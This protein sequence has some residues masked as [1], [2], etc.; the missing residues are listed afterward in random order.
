MRPIGQITQEH[1]DNEIQTA[2]NLC[3]PG[4]HE[5]I[6]TVFRSGNIPRSSCCFIDMEYCD[7]NLNNYIQRQWNSKMR[8]QFPNFIEP[9]PAD[10]AVQIWGIM[11]DI[12]NGVAFIHSHKLVHRDLKPQN[13]F[14]NAYHADLSSLF[15]QGVRHPWGLESGRFWTYRGSD[16]Q[17][18]T[19]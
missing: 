3:K 19:Y 12:A 1:I 7:L 6:V 5:N 8:S 10:E 11:I 15:P 2:L 16:V 13:S 9:T 18:T 4:A 14:P 17:A